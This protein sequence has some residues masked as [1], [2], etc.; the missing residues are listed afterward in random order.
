MRKGTFKYIEQIIEDYDKYDNLI[1]K[2]EQEIWHPQRE[3]DENIGGGQ[4]PRDFNMVE[5]LASRLVED[6]RLCRLK[7]EKDALD[8]AFRICRP[9]TDK[10]IRMWYLDKPR[11]KTWDGVAKEV[12]WSR[13]TCIN[14]RDEFIQS[15]ADE[16]GMI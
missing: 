13:R 5:R 14:L 8:R 1:K 10:I 16:L 2:R 3:T 7:D 12:N 15:V 4:R 9:G 6:E 11:L